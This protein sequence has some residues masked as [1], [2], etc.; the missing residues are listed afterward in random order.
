MRSNSVGNVIRYM[1]FVI[2]Y[3]INSNLIICAPQSK[4][5]GRGKGIGIV[6]CLKTV[7]M[8]SKSMFPVKYLNF[9]KEVYCVS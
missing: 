1:T 6:T 2:L 3:H 4:K 8:E 9:K 5:N 7:G